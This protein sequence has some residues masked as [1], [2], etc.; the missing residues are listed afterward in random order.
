MAL[1]DAPI[2]ATCEFLSSMSHLV[3][4]SA[5]GLGS[6]RRPADV[7]ARVTSSP[8]PSVT[9][10]TPEDRCLRLEGAP[11]S[12]VVDGRDFDGARVV[13]SVH[14][15]P[16]PEAPLGVAQAR[17]GGVRKIRT[18]ERWTPEAAERIVAA[19]MAGEALPTRARPTDGEDGRGFVLADPERDPRPLGAW[20]DLDRYLDAQ[21]ERDRTAFALSIPDRVL[22]GVLG[23]SGGYRVHIHETRPGRRV[24]FEARTKD[25][26]TERLDPGALRA[27]LASL[28][29]HEALPPG[30]R[31][32]VLEEGHREPGP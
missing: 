5:E 30:Y 26:N 31:P 1:V 13:W 3:W 32:S 7:L 25:S 17:V 15:Q 20:A 18:T 16:G 9:L 22:V 2:R 23:G 4:I 6:A 21:L 8:F 28:Y 12:V 24:A 29:R 19:F 14:G 10:S 11:S 27:V